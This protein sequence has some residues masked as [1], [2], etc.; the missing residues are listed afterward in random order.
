MNAVEIWNRQTFLA[1]DADLST[2]AWKLMAAT[3]AADYLIFLVPLALIAMWCW[4]GRVQRESA[5][6]ICLVA[7]VAL[8]INQLLALGYPHARP[9]Q[10]G[11]GHTFIPHAADASFPSDHATVFAA[12]AL[13][14][15]LAS[16]KRMAGW[17]FVILGVIVAW[18]RIYLG[19]HFPLDMLGAVAV[20]IVAYIGTSLLWNRAAPQCTG[21][22]ERLYR[23]VLARPI[24]LGWIRP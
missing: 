20:V 18:A 22:V 3:V 14:L 23:F 4:G 6:R 2:P 12:M 9:S 11:I 21:Q 7:L 16:P 8:G 1:W 10:M 15:L 13:T 19:V 5:L 17:I 24:A